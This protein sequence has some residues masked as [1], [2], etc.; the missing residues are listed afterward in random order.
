MESMLKRIIYI[1][2]FNSTYYLYVNMLSFISNIYAEYLFLE[3]DFLEAAV[4]VVV[5][6]L[7]TL[8]YIH[9]L[10]SVELLAMEAVC[11]SIY[12]ELVYY[13]TSVASNKDP[14][15]LSKGPLVLK[16]DWQK[17]WLKSTYIWLDQN[18]ILQWSNLMHE[19]FY[20]FLKYTFFFYHLFKI[21]VLEIFLPKKQDWKIILLFSSSI[22]FVKILNVMLLKTRTECCMF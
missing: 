14:V 1:S 13:T 2:F 18:I 15:R 11:T 21:I 3:L 19:Y 6:L 16:K 7:H 12:I 17:T 5:V 20:S 9:S 8:E 4:V 22:F 10:V